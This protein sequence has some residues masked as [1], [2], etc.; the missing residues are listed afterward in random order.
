MVENL[1]LF[2]RED[3]GIRKTVHKEGVLIETAQVE[4]RFEGITNR[5]LRA[6]VKAG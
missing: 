6:F 2:V 4:N 3:T 5:C 1:S